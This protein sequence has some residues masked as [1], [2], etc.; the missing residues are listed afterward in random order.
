MKFA[1]APLLVFAS[2]LV[3]SCTDAPV[4][5]GGTNSE[6]VARRGPQ[7]PMDRARELYEQALGRMRA[8]EFE[9][10]IELLEQARRLDPGSQD[11]EVLHGE[12]TRILA[13]RPSEWTSGSGRPAGD[14][15]SQSLLE[16][17]TQLMLSMD[18]IETL[19][20]RRA[21]RDVAEEADRAAEL[22]G[23]VRALA[24]EVAGA[25][26]FDAWD[27]HGMDAM[28]RGDPGVAT[29]CFESAL[30][31]A[32]AG[33]RI[34]CTSRAAAVAARL[35][36]C[37]ELEAAV[38][39]RKSPGSRP[40]ARLI[41]P[42]I[43]RSSVANRLL[44]VILTRIMIGERDDALRGLAS[45]CSLSPES[46]AARRLDQILRSFPRWD[47]WD[48]LG[49]WAARCN[50][51]LTRGMLLLRSASLLESRG[52]FRGAAEEF[53]ECRRLFHWMPL[54]PRLAAHSEEATSAA[55]RCRR[56]AEDASR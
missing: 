41:P 10:A 6:P 23:R 37:R 56:L 50:Q 34:V 12:A 52:D 43:D 28:G 9:A 17:R 3:A 19:I 15:G 54:N 46:Q 7:V 31:V 18:R 55:A 27:T 13:R 36:E 33:N 24:A 8:S 38:G 14:P 53:E 4:S 44:P 42:G 47:P 2:L 39:A 11:I 32:R 30:L 45:I 48:H 40:F 29:V 1:A 5:S 26:L 35:D 21:W 20:D 25:V 22:A 51:D 16:V 49:G